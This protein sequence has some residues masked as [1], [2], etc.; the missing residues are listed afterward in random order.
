MDSDINENLSDNLSLKCCLCKN[1]HRLMDCPSFKNKSI[2]ERRHF[3]NES[4]LCFNCLSKTHIVKD[5]KS[6]FICCEQN[7][8]KGYHV[9][10]DEPPN[11]NLNNN[12]ISDL[13]TE[14]K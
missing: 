5:C 7:C 1:N 9:F 11:V 2:S 6:S 13:C 10:L 12:L 3:V 4:K 8:N 14:N